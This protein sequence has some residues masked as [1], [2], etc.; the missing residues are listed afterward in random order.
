[1]KELEEYRLRL[2]ERL[3]AVAQ[4]FRR[5]C[6][7]VKDPHRSAQDGWS[8]HQIAAHTR[9]VDKLVYGWRARQTLERENPMFEDFDQNAFMAEHYKADEPLADILAKLITNVNALTDWLSGL[10]NEAW[11]RESQHAING[12]GLTLQTWIERDLAHLEEHLKALS[13]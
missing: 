12:A 9:D 8:V 7:A 6:L 4:E 3:R 2:L 13:E 1:M 10:P 5:A 11:A